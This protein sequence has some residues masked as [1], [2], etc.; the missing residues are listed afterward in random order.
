MF[1]TQIAVDVDMLARL[2][3]IAAQRSLSRE[4]ALREA[5]EGYLDEVTLRAEVAIG[6]ADVER[7]NVYPSGDV[8]SYFTGRRAQLLERLA[9]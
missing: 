4:D 6:R 9:R 2:D 5:V 3:A 1:L 8:E 7:G